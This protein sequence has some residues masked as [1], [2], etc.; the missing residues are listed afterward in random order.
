M[1]EYTAEH[2]NAL[3]HF[4]T[5]KLPSGIG[6]ECAGIVDTAVSMLP[7]GKLLH[8]AATLLARLCMSDSAPIDDSTERLIAVS[9][10]EQAH[11]VSPISR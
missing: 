5:R 8:S 10:S 9:V 2:T 3:N 1:S 11:Q 6:Q 7:G 4:V